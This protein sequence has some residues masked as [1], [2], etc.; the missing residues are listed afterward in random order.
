MANEKSKAEQ[1]RDERKARIAKAAKQN[2]K[3]MEK[4]TAAKKTAGKIISIILVAVIAIGIVGSTLNYYGVWDRTIVIGG[5][6]EDNVK[7]TAAEYEYYYMTVYNNFINQI[8]NYAAQ[9]GYDT[10]VAPDKQTGTFTD[11]TTG[12]ETPWAD[13]IRDGVISQ[14]KQV[15]T[16][17]N[18]AVKAGMELTAADKATVGNQIESLRSQAEQMGASENG[19]KYSLNAFL[20][21]YYG[22]FNESFMR[23]IVGQQVLAYNYAQNLVKEYSKNYSQ[24]EIDK[25]YNADK[26]AYDV[27]DV[28]IYTFNCETLEAN[29]GETDEA[30]A[31][32]QAKA[33]AEVKK[34]AEDFLKA[35]TNEQAF[36]AKAKALNTSDAEYDAETATKLRSVTKSAITENY[37][38]SED[39]ANW[40]FNAGTK[41]GTAKMFTTENSATTYTIFLLTKG[42][43]QEKTVNVRHIL[44]MTVDQQ[45]GEAFDEEK[46]AEAKKNADDAL[47]TWESGDKTEESFAALAADLS[48]DTGSQQTGGLYENVLPGSM[49]APFDSWIF[50]ANRK[51]GDTEIVETEYG[52]HVMYFVSANEQPY[53]DAVIRNEKANEEAETKADEILNAETNTIRFGVNNEG[54]GIKFA[55]NKVL[56]KITTILQMQSNNASATAGY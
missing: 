53:Y 36:V 44:F 15:K 28:R 56:K 39:V 8:G 17:Y 13:Y 43:H 22:P 55:E 11:P 42:M 6:G 27:V 35:A 24:E 4:K 14:I 51:A 31:A 29:E 10:S 18:E 1:Y 38:F 37:G 40:L 9:Y 34:N 52:Y 19:H 7:V 46:K 2:A 26:S 48:E 54:K 50:D 21:F 3:G 49:V 25:A 5:V 12:E 23:K 33:D 16:Y 32:R 41:V 30:L 45:T 47:K 20:R